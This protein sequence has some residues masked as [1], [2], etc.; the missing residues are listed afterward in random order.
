M[1]ILGLTSHKSSNKEL[2]SLIS[3]FDSNEEVESTVRTW[4]KWKTVEYSEDKFSKF[5]LVA[6]LCGKWE[7]LCGKIKG[8]KKLFKLKLWRGTISSTLFKTTVT[9][10]RLFVEILI[11]PGHSVPWTENVSWMWSK[12]VLKEKTKKVQLTFERA[13]LGQG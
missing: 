11:H 5:C 4:L 1:T 12:N 13:P 7:W 10:L 6:D 9:R 8:N 3:L 2:W